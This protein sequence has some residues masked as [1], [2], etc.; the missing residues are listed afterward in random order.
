MKLASLDIGSNSIHMIVVETDGE[1]S[2]EV[3]DRAKEMVLL[4]RSVFEHA[5]LSDD[6]FRAGISA[7]SKL[8]KLAE[9]HGVERTRAVATSA[10][11]EA[12]NGVEFLHALTEAVGL[13]AEVISGREE[14]RYIY[15]AVRSALDLATRPAL[16]IDC[17]GG[18]VE[19]IVGDARE[20]RLA[21]SL[22]LGVQRL[23]ARFGPGP[24]EKK[25]RKELEALVRRLAG[26]VLEAARRAG[27][28]LVVGTSGTISAL[29]QAAQRLRGGAP[30]PTLTGQALGL[31]E[32]RALADRLAPL[33]PAERVSA[34]G[35]DALRADTLHLGA[36]L[37]ERLLTLSGKERLV[38]SSAALR[39][40]VI[41]DALEGARDERSSAELE[42]DVRRQSVLELMRRAGQTGPHPERVARL[43]LSLFDQTREL[44]RL[45]SRERMLLEYAALLHDVGQLI[46]YERHEH[47]AAYIIRN[48]ELRGFSELEREL[49]AQLT[50]YHRKARPKRRDA[51]F[52]ALS[53]RARRAVRVL[54]GL[55]RVADGL[56]RGHHQIVRS[57]RVERAGRALRVV[58]QTTADSELELWGARCKDKLMARALGVEVRLEVEPVASVTLETA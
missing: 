18:S 42:R 10:I 43:A 47:H 49:I 52:M 48:S 35:L 25:A 31:D 9:R 36:V 19:L 24:L 8:V 40:G 7:V 26:P 45:G 41:I 38:L 3:I 44:H 46:G 39:E 12:A 16:I 56:D 55:L 32:L 4:G 21:A 11:R 14:A 15:L 27:F 29:G 1:R 23:R 13:E 30:S 50:R 53:P 22:E 20:E 2:F 34:L 51:D 37:V 57:V 6:A 33:T 28:D 58:A 5:R 17:G 54:A